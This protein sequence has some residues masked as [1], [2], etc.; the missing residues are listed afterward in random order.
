METGIQ[1]NRDNKNM[2]ML[3]IQYFKKIIQIKKL[4]DLIEQIEPF[5]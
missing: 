2:K 3:K 5:Y 1:I 4:N